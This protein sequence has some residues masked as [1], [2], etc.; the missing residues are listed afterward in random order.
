M[1]DSTRTTPFTSGDSAAV[2]AVI[3]AAKDKDLL[4]ELAHVGVSEDA[5]ESLC[6][7]S[8]STQDKAEH[9]E[10]GIPNIDAGGD[11]KDRS[12]TSSSS[13]RDHTSPMP[14]YRVGTSSN[15]SCPRTVQG[16]EDGNETTPTSGWSGAVDPSATGDGLGRRMTGDETPF[17]ELKF[18]NEVLRQQ[19]Q[20]A[21][22]A[23]SDLEKENETLKEMLEQ[24]S[25]VSGSHSPRASDKISPAV[26]SPKLKP[27]PLPRK[28]LDKQVTIECTKQP[29]LDVTQSGT[30]LEVH[31]LSTSLALSD[32]PLPVKPPRRK[33]AEQKNLAKPPLPPYP[34]PG[35][36]D[37]KQ[38]PDGVVQTT[39][40]PS[41]PSPRQRLHAP[42]APSQ[43]SAPLSS[44]SS[45]SSPGINK[46]IT[47]IKHDSSWITSRYPVPTSVARAP[48]HITV[49]AAPPVIPTVESS[50]ANGTSPTKGMGPTKGIS[51]T[52]P[53]STKV[54]E[55]F[56]SSV[57]PGDQFKSKAQRPRKF[58]FLRRSNPQVLPKTEEA[59]LE[60]V[61][62]QNSPNVASRPKK[63][64][65]KRPSVSP[66]HERP[67]SVAE[68]TSVSVWVWRGWCI[69]G[70]V[71]V[72]GMVWTSGCGGDGV[73]QW[74]WRG[75]CGPVGVE[76][77]VWT[78][79]CG[80]DG[81][82]QW[83][84]RGWCGPVGVEGMVW[85]SGCG[86]D[87]VDQWVW[88][89]WCG[90]V[91]VEGMVWTSGCGGDGVDQW[92]WRGWCGPVGV[93]GMVWTSGCGGDGVDQWVWR[94]W[95]MWTSGVWRGWCICGPVG[96][97]GMVYMWT[98]GCGGDGGGTYSGT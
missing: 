61:V 58:S 76:G 54:S 86:G 94:G 53:S 84:W 71:G 8:S 92:V 72:E 78:S 25:T 51:P 36:L 88:R 60:G 98:S 7:R 52:G 5:V 40:P 66:D 42:L 46:R 9:S 50:P 14:A 18:E 35:K 83:V 44:S 80:G 4:K 97:E 27:V 69:C 73:D 21:K 81:V 2:S 3:K 96:V 77:M 11:P 39:H 31:H 13:E 63:A 30:A 23:R 6:G 55:L 56:S 24:H 59:P 95:C 12:H 87:G 10:T 67:A 75:W 64:A 82:D 43:S 19:L 68:N 47:P 32:E 28:H 85:T 15:A 57:E 49:K 48:P 74:V 62:T 1:D 34:S 26:S 93:E 38:L 33:A 29:R 90:P 17:R 65:K 41:A 37:I 89:G 45:S 70:P 16:N 22:V 79:G 20:H 91:G